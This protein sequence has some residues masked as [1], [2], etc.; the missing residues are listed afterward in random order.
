MI[1][2]SEIWKDIETNKTTQVSN[3]GNIKSDKKIRCFLLSGYKRVQIFNKQYYVHRLVAQA[4]VP[5]P[6]NKPCVNHINGNKLDNRAE[7]LEWCTYSENNAHAYKTGLKQP[8]TKTSK[9]KNICMLNDDKEI[10]C[11]FPKMNYVDKI[12][13]KRVS[14]NIVR[15]IKLGQ[16]CEGY[17]WENYYAN[18]LNLKVK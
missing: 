16:K 14:S 15:A 4:F 12:F 5:N 17:Y 6:E 18:D 1:F 8:N 10:V 2:L 11:I 13:N 3:L 9:H 7:N